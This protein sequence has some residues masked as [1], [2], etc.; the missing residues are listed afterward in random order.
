M[1]E[2]ML[3]SLIILCAL[4]VIFAL[5]LYF[6]AQKFKVVEDPRIDEVVSLLPGA[7]CGGCGFAGC[8]ALAEFMVKNESFE[9]KCPSL[10]DAALAKIAEILGIE[11]T[12]SDPKIAVV[13]CNG[14]VANAPKKVLYNAASSCFYANSIFGGESG[15]PN[16]C[17]GLGDC[18]SACQF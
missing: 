13:R 17:L 9:A 3:F 14:S 12:K 6:V 16:G 10:N 15:C 8:R 5:I 2:I 7:N 18:V 1:N 11:A 4:G